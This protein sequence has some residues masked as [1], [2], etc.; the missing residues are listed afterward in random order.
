M[1]FIITL[2]SYVPG[3]RLLPF[4]KS[5]LIIFRIN[6]RRR[7]IINNA[8]GLVGR[9]YLPGFSR[10]YGNWRHENENENEALKFRS[11][12]AGNA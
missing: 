5:S 6:L 11:S 7:E 9:N 1:T 4:A 12:I 10:N 2:F 8:D 3:V